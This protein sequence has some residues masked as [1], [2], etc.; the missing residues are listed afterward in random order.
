MGAPPGSAARSGVAAPQRGGPRRGKGGREM[1]LLDVFA[2]RSS[3]SEYL[4]GDS[5][6][7]VRTSGG[8]DNESIQEHEGVTGVP[9]MEPPATPDDVAARRRRTAQ[10]PPATPPAALADP[11]PL[12]DLSGGAPPLPA[13][14]PICASASPLH[15][16]CIASASPLHRLCAASAPPLYPV[17]KSLRPPE[18]RARA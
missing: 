6:S 16:L 10:E 17:P 8:Q 1:S 5:G 4:G 15:R 12:A 2:G 18:A 11:I 7:P 3:V 9:S 13:A 14:A